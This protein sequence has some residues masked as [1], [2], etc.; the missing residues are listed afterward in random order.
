MGI[1]NPKKETLDRLRSKTLDDR[2][3]REIVEGLNCSPFEAEAVLDVVREVYAPLHSQASPQMPPG[4]ISLVAVCADAPA[5]KSISECQKRSVCLTLH[6]G[7]LDDRLLLQSAADF[8]QQRIPDLCQQALSQGAL[9]TIEDLAFRVFFVSTRTISRDLAQLR[10]D[11]PQLVIPLRSNVQDIGPVLTHRTEIVKLAL[12]GKT[13]SQICA[14]MRHSPQAVAN[15]IST[16]TRVAQLK[17]QRMQPSQIAFLLRRGQGLIQRYL[18]L[19]EQCKGDNNMTYHLQELLRLGT[20]A[21][22]QTEDNEKKT[23]PPRRHPDGR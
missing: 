18:E 11:D 5:G 14:I 8:R 10:K 9:L 20:I 22:N 15:Y 6:R 16:F 17:Q 2:F 12:Q 4:R 19:F 23:K 21:D 1:R 3:C 13:T 7:D